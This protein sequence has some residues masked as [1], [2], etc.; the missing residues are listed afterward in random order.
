MVD[1]INFTNY[2]RTTYQLEET[3]LFSLLVAGKNALTTSR[4][5]DTFIK[6]FKFGNET[7]FE[8][9][10]KFNLHQIPKLS[11]VLKDYGFGCYNNK[12]KGIH[13]LVRAE[14]DL[15]TCSVDDLEKIHGIG[16]KTANLFLMHTRKDYRCGCLDTHI[17]KF[18]KE[19]GYDVPKATPSSKKKYKE[20]ESIFIS[21]CDE[22]KM[23]S[24]EL[25][26][27]IWRHYSGNS[28]N[29]LPFLNSQLPKVVVNFLEPNIV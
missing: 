5:L 10:S 29:D 3:L 19:K 2:N 13:Q 27:A 28:K 22:L 20:I 4:L 18:L 24:A 23:D 7:P 26:L 21:I 25:D 15:K 6:D 12:A 1:P 17:L 16:R 9:F 14:L 11:V 8:V